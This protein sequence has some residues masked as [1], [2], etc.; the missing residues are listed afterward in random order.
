MNGKSTR[1]ELS[2]YNTFFICIGILLKYMHIINFFLY[3]AHVDSF[4][5]HFVSILPFLTPIC[6]RDFLGPLTVCMANAIVIAYDRNFD[7]MILSK[8]KNKNGHV[9]VTL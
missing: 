4:A 1:E 7:V 5:I 9:I 2:I 3:A 8:I 6:F